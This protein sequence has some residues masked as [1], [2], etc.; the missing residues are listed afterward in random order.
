MTP[1]KIVLFRGGGTNDA[2]AVEQVNVGGQFGTASDV[3]RATADVVLMGG[4]DG[5]LGLLDLSK[6][7]FRRI[8]FNFVWSALYNVFAILLAG[9]VF[10]KI[11]I[12]SACAGLGEVVSV[13]PVIVGVFTLLKV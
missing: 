6:H 1:R 13:V 12:P 4:L 3:A 5:L 7:S 11:R 2:V 8:V 9:G 10:V